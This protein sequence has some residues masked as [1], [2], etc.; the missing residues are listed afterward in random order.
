MGSSF[1]VNIPSC[2]AG[3]GYKATTIKVALTSINQPG[4]TDTDDIKSLRDDPT[5]KV[6]YAGKFGVL[7]CRVTRD[8]IQ[9]NYRDSSFTLN[10]VL[11]YQV[12]TEVCANTK[13]EYCNRVLQP[14]SFYRVNF[15]ILDENGSPKAYTDWSNPVQ[16]LNVTDVSAI[17]S[18]LQRRSGGMVVITVLLSVALFILVVCLPITLILE[19]KKAP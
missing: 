10:I 3:T 9:V 13:G 11:G 15:F 16:T 14:A 1:I 6:Y 2:L 5:A 17:Q 18:G 12:G 8:V 4:V 19:K 7:P